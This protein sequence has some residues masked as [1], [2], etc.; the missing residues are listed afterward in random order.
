MDVA[1]SSP[2]QFNPSD[3]TSDIIET[4]S[5]MSTEK[6]LAPVFRLEQGGDVGVW[7]IRGNHFSATLFGLVS[8]NVKFPDN[9][10]FFID[11]EKLTRLDQ[12][13]IFRFCDVNLDNVHRWALHPNHGLGPDYL[14]MQF[15]EK[16]PREWMLIKRVSD[17][18]LTLS[19]AELKRTG[20]SS[21]MW[22]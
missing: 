16:Y 22:E 14:L 17:W 20:V 4:E 19:I 1:S 7:S 10:I 11:R 15:R 21:D 13:E 3:V 12:K 9:I 2:S 5:T 8:V 18:L 6:E